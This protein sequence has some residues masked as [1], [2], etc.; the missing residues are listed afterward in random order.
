MG[1]ERMKIK[2]TLDG[3]AGELDS[4][5]L[6]NPKAKNADDMSDQI[7]DVIGGWTLSAGDT[8]T[9]REV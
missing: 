1:D 4:K 8:I 9:I 6:E 5:V 7:I 3:G 2:V